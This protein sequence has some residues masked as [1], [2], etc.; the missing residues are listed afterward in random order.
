MFSSVWSLCV[1]QLTS[2]F[3]SRG[4]RFRGRIK[5]S[6]SCRL[7][8]ERIEDR[9]VLSGRTSQAAL[10]SAN[11]AAN[12]AG[13]VNTITLAA[14][15]TLPEASADNTNHGPN[16][17]P[18]IAA[19][20]NHHPLVDNRRKSKRVIARTTWP[21]YY[22][23]AA[24]FF[25]GVVAIGVVFII[26]PARAAGDFRVVGGLSVNG[27]AQD[28]YD[29]TGLV[30]AR[31]LTYDKFNDP[32]E[33]NTS[34]HGQANSHASIVG[35]GAHAYANVIIEPAT[36]NPFPSYISVSGQASAIAV[37]KDVTVS[38]PTGMIPVSLNLFLRGEQGDGTSFAVVGH[39]DDA[40]ESISVTAS[41]NGTNIGSGEQELFSEDGSPAATTLP[42]FGMLSNWNDL[43]GGFVTPSFTVQANVPF[44]L[45]LDLLAEAGASG[46]N[47]DS[48]NNAA[49]ADFGST[50][51]F[52]PNGPVFNLPSGYL[53]SSSDAGIVSNRFI[54][55]E[56]SGL[57][58]SCSWMGA[59][60]LGW[61]RKRFGGDLARPI[62][63]F[64]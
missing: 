16:G 15:I 32:N 52:A 20:D 12:A 44:T 26:R 59:L 27:A 24:A 62:V 56:P 5:K 4:P 30:E 61:S 40:E 18:S 3:N 23:A 7:R 53:A 29:E 21:T 37:F 63:R 36:A 45:Q 43:V 55:P 6:A 46:L 58:L 14:N 35:L 50:L 9:R 31:S 19:G 57:M 1:E 38:G 10:I 64:N 34:Y 33:P 54:A 60:I 2:A 41:V 49:N 48:F 47:T 22:R 39:R 28:Q 8:F 51:T 25:V 13:V 17:L 42:S 11:N